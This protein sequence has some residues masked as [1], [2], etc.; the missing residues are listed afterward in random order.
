MA[1]RISDMTPYGGTPPANALLEVSVP[2]GAGYA[3]FSVAAGDLGGGGGDIPFRYRIDSRDIPWQ[4]DEDGGYALFFIP[5]SAIRPDYQSDIPFPEYFADSVTSGT[6]RFMLRYTINTVDENSFTSMIEYRAWRNSSTW[7]AAITDYAATDWES[8]AYELPVPWSGV[9]TA[10]S[11][12]YLANVYTVSEW[13]AG[14]TG[15]FF[16]VAMPGYS[17]GN[18]ASISVLGYIDGVLRVTFSSNT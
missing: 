1:D 7:K 14:D 9:G 10:N 18:V 3:T 8:T 13:E 6:L 16:R 15:L 5:W 17:D 11:A 12:P 2:Q 4:D